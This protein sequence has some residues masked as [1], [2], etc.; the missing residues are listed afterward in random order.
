MAKM[1]KTRT[2]EENM[3]ARLREIA[4]EATE[5]DRKTVADLIQRAVS[6]KH[7][8]AIYKLTPPVCAIKLKGLPNAKEV[9][10]ANP[11]EGVIINL[12]D[13]EFE[14]MRG[15]FFLQSG[16]YYIEHMNG[17]MKDKTRG[18]DPRNFII[19]MPLKELLSD[20]VLPE[21]KEYK[22]YYNL[23]IEI[24]N[25]ITAGSAAASDERFKLIG[26]WADTKRTIDIHNLGVKRRFINVPALYRSRS[27]KG[28]L[29][30]HAVLKESRSNEVERAFL[31]VFDF[32]A[33]RRPRRNTR[34]RRNL[35]LP[36]GSLSPTRRRC[37][38]K[39]S[40]RNRRWSSHKRRPC[41]IP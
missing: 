33:W 26:R 16:V 15:G 6:E 38:P 11:P 29:A 37:R 41:S 14:R 35:R 28:I 1:I 36:C 5:E 3:V 30:P 34:A 17:K 27:R 10:N 19:K 23:E 2:L 22:D 13:W 25:Y 7:D 20:R 12:G 32:T 40:S 8:S 24:R 18:A 4:K 21:W 31:T 9:F 39:A